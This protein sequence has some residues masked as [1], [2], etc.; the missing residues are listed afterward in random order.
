M[1]TN[2]P[3]R[4]PVRPK[5]ANAVL[6]DEIAALG[7]RSE[8]P[9]ER[10][11]NIGIPRF[12]SQDDSQEQGERNLCP[13]NHSNVEKQNFLL[14]DAEASGEY[15]ESGEMLD[16]YTFRAVLSIAIP[17]VLVSYFFITYIRWLR[18]PQDSREGW[19]RKGYLDAAEFINYSWFVL[20]TFALN[21]ATYALSGSVASMVMTKTW[22]PGSAR[23][24]VLLAESTFTDPSSWVSRIVK[25]VKT[26]SVSTDNSGL[27]WNMLSILSIIGFVAWPLT[28]LTMQTVDGYS[29]NLGTMSRHSVIG[30]NLS[31]FN[32][33]SGGNTQI[34]AF[35]L[36]RLGLT[37]HLP[38]LQQIFSPEGLPSVLNTTGNMMPDEANIPIFLG[39]QADGPIFGNVFGL[40]VRYNCT[41]VTSIS[42]FTV[43]S[44]RRSTSYT[45]RLTAPFY[46][47]SDSKGTI[48][49]T[50]QAETP[51]YGELWN[52]K[53]AMEVG[54]SIPKRNLTNITEDGF[55][56]YTPIPGEG[57]LPGL[58]DFVVLEVALWQ[59][60]TEVALNNVV[61]EGFQYRHAETTIPELDGAYPGYGSAVGVRC[62]AS[63][64]IGYA[65]VDGSRATFSNFERTAAEHRRLL[66]FGVKR[67]QNSIHHLLLSSPN[68]FF[69]DTT[70]IPWFWGIYLYGSLQYFPL[71]S[72]VFR[73][74][75]G[76]VGSVIQAEE[77]KESVLRAYKSY[78]VQLM[79]DGLPDALARWEMRG[80]S[81]G[82]PSKTLI[83]GVV[84]AEIVFALLS[85]WGLSI[86][87][88][89]LFYQF[90]RRWTVKLDAF[91]MFK[92]GVTR[93]EDITPE[94][95]TGKRGLQ[96]LEALPGTVGDL[97]ASSPVGEIGLVRGP[98]TIARRR[99]IYVYSSRLSR[100]LL[101]PSDLPQ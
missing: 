17:L 63:S 97:R 16:F 91:S 6:D 92:F 101:I 39:P 1:A 90:S 83:R 68:L 47:T 13:T 19:V 96:G 54:V 30:R 95:L 52:I 67:F 100:I 42:N 37:P 36:W 45:N 73:D 80:I 48:F 87:L 70:S 74:A 59:N 57:D 51:R 34:R 86:I 22:G 8:T 27:L 78:A 66:P 75:V 41:T 56:G 29:I 64:D 69:D 44:S 18:Y 89:A 3:A 88:L 50:R 82:T 21:L 32:S 35:D 12:G 10:K 14:V 81:V 23:V 94:Q 93:P 60:L 28:G 61:P 77:L 49:F 7:H 65:D 38:L 15:A 9:P 40:A 31:S 46:E 62:F 58:D 55:D 53:M 98:G 72:N 2:I 4:K 11:G 5:A 33:R 79:Y 85:I 26:R 99:K 43:L 24:L 76:L 84:P 20:G 25:I 71:T